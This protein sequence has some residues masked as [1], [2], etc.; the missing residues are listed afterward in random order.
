MLKPSCQ[1][2]HVNVQLKAN[3]SEISSISIIR[4][5]VVNDDM[6]PIRRYDNSVYVVYKQCIVMHHINPDGDRKDL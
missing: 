3:I 4:V 5:D 2:S 6:P 1:I